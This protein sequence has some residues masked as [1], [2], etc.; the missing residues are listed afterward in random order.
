MDKANEEA[1]CFGNTANY[2][3]L[4]KYIL[5]LIIYFSFCPAGT[6]NDQITIDSLIKKAKTNPN[7]SIKYS[8][9]RKIDNLFQTYNKDSVMSK[10]NSLALFFAEDKYYRCAGYCYYNLARELK[11]NG[12]YFESYENYLKSEKYYQDIDDKP[13]LAE[14]YNGLGSLYKYLDRPEESSF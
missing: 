3:K 6:G 5:F 4:I 13:G 9:L 14:V 8:T 12:D 10:W 11:N 7:D 1:G 2:M